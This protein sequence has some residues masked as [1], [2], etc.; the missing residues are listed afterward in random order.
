MGDIPVWIPAWLGNI[1]LPTAI[2]LFGLALAR[3]WLYTR[4]QI[5]ELLSSAKQV[6]ELWE[7]VAGERQETIKLLTEATEPVVQGNAAILRALEEI[8]RQQV[9]GRGGRR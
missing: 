5:T 7:K 8:Q 6:S 4:G 9:Q 3:N 1:S 2:A